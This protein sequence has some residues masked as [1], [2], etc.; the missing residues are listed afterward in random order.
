MKVEKIRELSADELRK[1]IREA[2]EKLSTLVLR[3]QTGQIENPN[4]IR[5]TRKTIARLETILA[6]K[7]IKS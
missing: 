7:A 5:Q 2:R 4:E 6:E 3:K 1:S